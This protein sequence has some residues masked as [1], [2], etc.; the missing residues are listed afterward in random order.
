MAAPRPVGIGSYGT[1]IP[2]CRITV[3]ECL[4]VWN[5]TFLDILK[6]HV[7]IGERAVILPD[8]DTI[9]MSVE[10]ARQALARLRPQPDLAA[11][12]LGTCTNPY[13]SRPSSTLIAEALARQPWTACYDVQF[14]TKSGTAALQLAAA[15]VQSGAA[16]NALAIGADTINKHVAPGTLQEYSGSAGAA[17]FFVTD[18]PDQ[19]IAE[20]GPFTSYSS[21]LS[22][23]F[24]VSGERYIRSGGLATQES[25]VG[26][27]EHIGHAIER[28]LSITG[29]TTRDFDSVVLHQPVA[30]VPVA[31]GLKLGFGMDQITPGLVAYELGDLGSAGVGIALANILD[32]AEPGERILLASYGFGAGADVTVI[33]TRPPI[34]T[35]A[36]DQASV[37]QQIADKVM[38]DYATATKYEHKYAKVDHALTAWS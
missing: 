19:M 24:R 12:L 37:E 26:F 17:A 1:F 34:R 20:I 31:L 32:S 11:L 4:R 33:T 18:D 30:V 27:L 10:A 7:M 21:D 16:R 14:S 28:H 9:T 13:E 2:R 22:D 6:E 3:E 23:A 29:L 15:L 38:L 35:M 8:Q 36:R 25:G 5:N